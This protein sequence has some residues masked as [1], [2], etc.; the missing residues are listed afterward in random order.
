MTVKTVC[1]RLNITQIELSQRLC[2][3]EGTINRWASLGDDLSLNAKAQLNLLIEND[4]F[5]KRLSVSTDLFNS[6]DAF[7]KSRQ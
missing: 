7:L 3:S 2:L 4:Y 5:L 6:L 1:D